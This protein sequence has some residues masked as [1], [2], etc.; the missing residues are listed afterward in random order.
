MES[1]RRVWGYLPV[2][3][4]LEGISCQ[5]Q[6]RFVQL[7]LELARHDVAPDQV[8]RRYGHQLW[9]Y[10]VVTRGRADRMAV[11][12]MDDASL[13]VWAHGPPAIFWRRLERRMVRLRPCASTGT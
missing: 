11:E 4:E 1:A 9:I 6:H 7:W 5:A 8:W 2:P 13:L 12:L 10:T 3:Q